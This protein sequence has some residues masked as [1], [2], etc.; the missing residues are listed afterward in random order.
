[1]NKNLGSFPNAYN[2]YEAM[3]HIITFSS[4]KQVMS[5]KITMKYC[6]GVDLFLSDRNCRPKVNSYR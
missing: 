4:E 5:M 6:N 2:I 1:M 3:L